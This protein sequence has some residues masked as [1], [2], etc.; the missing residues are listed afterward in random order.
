MIWL[1]IGGLVY[2]WIVY[3]SD[4]LGNNDDAH[5]SYN[6]LKRLTVSKNSFLR[7]IIPLKEGD[8]IK[9]G[10]ICVHRYYLYPRVLAVFIQSIII[11]IGLI[12]LAIHLF[13]FPFIPDL[14]LG[15]VGG[16]LLG[17]C[18]IYTLVMSILSQGLHI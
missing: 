9:N 15:I 14:I 8:I 13:L 12:I 5:F 11:L 3:F 2:P 4:L 7:K 1:Y 17:L 6:T 16:I 18:I 10:K